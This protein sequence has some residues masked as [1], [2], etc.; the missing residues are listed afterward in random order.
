[1]VTG[2]PPQGSLPPTDQGL[3]G[4]YSYGEEKM[5]WAHLSPAVSEWN[6]VKWSL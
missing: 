5:G 4:V 3:T 6:W 2:E 1:M